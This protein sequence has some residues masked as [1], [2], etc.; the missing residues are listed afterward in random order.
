MPLDVVLSIGFGV[1]WLG[2]VALVR[3]RGPRKSRSLV[4]QLP[5]LPLS[6]ADDGPVPEPIRLSLRHKSQRDD[7]AVLNAAVLELA[8]AGLFEIEPA[9]SQNPAMVSPNVLPHA[10]QL[11]PYQ[12]SVVARL[13]HRRGVTQRPVPLTALQPGEDDS[14][15]KWHKDFTKQVRHAAVERG[16]LQPPVNWIQFAAMALFGFWTANSVARAAHLG[17]AA[18]AVVVGLCLPV[19]ITVA[20]ASQVRPTA[21]GRALLPAPEQPRPVAT[22][23]AATPAAAPTAPL[24]PVAVLPNQLQPL[25]ANQV[26]SDYGGSWHPLD[27]NSTETYSINSGIPAYFLL[28]LF[29]L[30]SVGGLVFARRDGDPSGALPFAIFGALPVLLLVGAGASYARRR[31]LPKRAVIRGQVAKLWTVTH[32]SEDSNT[33]YYYCSLDVGRAPQ[34]VRLKIHRTLYGRLLVGAEIEVLVNPRRRSI[35]DLRFLGP[36][37]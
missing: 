5:P 20:W 29:A 34:S 35:K 30:I 14:S 37:G 28:I 3:W 12:A 26:W 7:G 19:A 23:A 8:E 31:R 11:P 36:E 25:P 21:A 1:L 6:P 2:S 17:A 22:A 27:V 15:A 32:R 16:L 4:P 24:A 9:D 13:L 10:S 18:P 33:T